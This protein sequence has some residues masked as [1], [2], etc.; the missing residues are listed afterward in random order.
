MA[1]RRKE[2]CKRKI[3]RRGCT[4]WPIN[5]AAQPRGYQDCYVSHSCG[6]LDQWRYLK[7]RQ[8]RVANGHVRERVGPPTRLAKL[9]RKRPARCSR[10]FVIWSPISGDAGLRIV[11]E[12]R[13]DARK[14]RFRVLS[15]RILESKLRQTD[16][17][18]LHTRDLLLL[19]IPQNETDHPILSNSSI[20]DI[21]GKYFRF[22]VFVIHCIIDD[23]YNSV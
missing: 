9:R 3:N 6:K 22:T 8:I 2:E 5:C 14:S 15:F 1:K 20:P 17:T 13:G 16:C 10:P 21:L 18:C 12:K 11:A 7:A 23:L 4:R 19:H